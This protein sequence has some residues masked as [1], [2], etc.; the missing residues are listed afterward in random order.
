M[1][2]SCLSD[3]G[4][5]PGGQ[6]ACKGMTCNS[7]CPQNLSVFQDGKVLP[8]CCIIFPCIAFPYIASF[9]LLGSPI[10]YRAAAMHMCGFCFSSVIKVSFLYR[11]LDLTLLC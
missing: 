8:L 4:C 10:D 6:F 5:F 2:V 7:S 9:L 1:S 11:C 3:G